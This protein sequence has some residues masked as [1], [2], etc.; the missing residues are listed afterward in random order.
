M[1]KSKPAHTARHNCNSNKPPLSQNC[2]RAY[3][4]SNAFFCR[5]EKQNRD[6]AKIENEGEVL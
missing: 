1:L 2:N 6:S 4:F 5:P 3:L